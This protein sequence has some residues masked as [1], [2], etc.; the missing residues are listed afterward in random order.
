MTG[1]SAIDEEPRSVDRAGHASVAAGPH[2]GATTEASAD[3]NGEQGASFL[4]DA[5][6][7]MS[8]S[9]SVRRISMATLDMLAPRLADWA[10]LVLFE[11]RSTVTY[12]TP[13]GT[14]ALHAADR[15]P[16]ALTG[17][18]IEDA[19]SGLGRVRATGESQFL[20]APT[21]GDP[22]G[23]ARPIHGLDGVIPDEGLR[24]ELLARQ[25]DEVFTLP[26]SAR[27]RTFGALTLARR[28]PFSA[29]Q[30]VLA[31]ELADRLA[32]SLDSARLYEERTH[33][34]TVLQRSLRPPALPEIPG[35]ALAAKFRA[36][37]EHMDIGGDFY[38]VHG[39]DNDYLL[40]LGDVCGKGVEAAVLTGR[41][42]QTIRT[43]AHLD[44]TPSTI[45]SVL[46]E[47]LYDN[48]SDRFV[49][50]VCARVRTRAGK[51]EV[52]VA[53]GGHPPP[54]ILHPDGTLDTVHAAGVL[55]GVISGASY[56]Q[57]SVE[58]L[59][60]DVM[61]MFTD[62]IYEARNAAGFF[63]MDRLRALLPRY[64]GSDPAVLCDAIDAAVVDFL[65]GAPHDDMALLAI[66]CRE[67]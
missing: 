1:Q 3:G 31:E 63:G 33:V 48:D 50:A 14:K 59:H 18:P 41:S 37:I 34:A 46:N 26:L 51:A 24:A 56:E 22:T 35:M 21:A 64:A 5:A 6:R 29:A 12:A 60:G 25:P 42:R 52:D 17:P 39:G 40:A 43:V 62:G 55:C 66:G 36:A 45:L 9:L 47:V 32:I 44:R 15:V 54:I 23:A 53:V 27:D 57:T 67:S 61:L 20:R 65:G 16:V 8:G 28:N 10:Q 19:H 58:L 2:G 7:R 11:V 4:L 49:T 30:R 38:D 13:T